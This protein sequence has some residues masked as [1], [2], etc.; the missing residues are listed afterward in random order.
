V[1]CRARLA[2]E[3]AAAGAFLI[4]QPPPP[5]LD[6]QALDLFEA[7]CDWPELG[8]AFDER[9]RRAC[10]GDAALLKLVRAL[11]DQDWQATRII[12]SD[13]PEPSAAPP[14]LP[15]QIARWRIGELLGVGGMGSVYRGERV[16]GVFEQ[17]VA[18]KLIRPGVLSARMRE[19]FAAERRT[20]AR[21]RHP[22]IAQLYDGGTDAASGFDWF[23]M[24]Y[25]DGE[26]ITAHV[27]REG[28]GISRCIE[29]CLAACE[30]VQHAHQH[31]VVHADL[32]PANMLV[33]KAGALK[34]LDFGI[35]HSLKPALADVASSGPWPAATSPLTPAYA[36]PERRAGAEPSIAGDVYSLGVVF[37]EMLDPLLALP[38]ADRPIDLAAVLA[39]ARAQLP[40]DRYATVAAL[41]ED[42]QRYRDCFPVRA[43]PASP[44]YTLR[45]FLRRRRGPVTL[46]ASLALALLLATIAS[47][48]LY[49]R[50]QRAVAQ[51]RLRFNEL[52]QLSR[53]MIF[54]LYDEFARIPGT[55]SARHALVDT[56]RQYLARLQT[57]TDAPPD[58]QLEILASQVR[59]ATV[60]GVPG[61]PNLGEVAAS[62]ALLEQATQGLTQLRA[63]HPRQA[64]IDTELAFAL[65][66][67]A[68][69]A[70][71]TEQRLE[72]A[73]PL[74]AQARALAGSSGG[75]SRERE[76]RQLLWLR[77][78]ELA[79]WQQQP[80]RE[81]QVAT[82]ALRDLA[83]WPE[84]E[85]GDERFAVLHS[86]M[87]LRLADGTYYAD[88][89]AAALP[90]YREAEA[91]LDRANQQWPERSTLLYLWQQANW[92]IATTLS[93]L[94]QQRQSLP[95]FE[96]AIAVLDRL[97]QRERNDTALLYAGFVVRS[98]HA[99]QLSMLG[100]HEQALA[101]FADLLA[102]RRARLQAAPDDT[103]ATRGVA[104]E[105]FTYGLALERAGRTTQAC[106]ALRE[107]IAGFEGLQQ[108]ASLSEWDR[109]D[110]LEKAQQRYSQLRCRP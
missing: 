71:W 47:S 51:E 26:S 80:Q 8:P 55:T 109:K 104:V 101:A 61:G 23:A 99:E 105:L 86:R 33:S 87:L 83:S 25:V 20:L 43:L 67:R 96:K 31:L 39:R 29:L 11:L 22:G 78:C 13:P 74:L 50:A 69:I 36:S 45:R 32:K 48:A 82:E 76:V 57:G 89:P 21:L 38:G 98:A 62:K 17:T 59:L 84:A 2:V 68:A 65:L 81:L 54:E 30:A 107:G 6:Q 56:A 106:A 18:I 40:G 75:S 28:C 35:A 63:A 72:A 9:L 53:Y 19:T 16:D 1:A 108:R 7:S 79:D 73:Q 41:A 66:Q 24:E 70:I 27:R 10:E 60:M 5:N 77:E 58:L 95:P 4:V 92:S 85:R 94:G 91:E 3:R 97:Q 34:L 103:S 93:T 12:P 102:R 46:V 110:H 15:R 64:G 14:P 100:R 52:R 90:L 88:S 37:A 42:L 44:A 49:L